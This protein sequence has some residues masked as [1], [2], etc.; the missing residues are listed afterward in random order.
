MNFEAGNRLQRPHGS[1]EFI[2]YLFCDSDGLSAR[3]MFS[4]VA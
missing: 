4:L 1:T 3:V 2:P